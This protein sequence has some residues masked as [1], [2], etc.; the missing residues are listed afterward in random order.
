[1]RLSVPASPKV[2][3]K[4]LTNFLGVDYTSILPSTRRS[5]HL[6]N[7]TNN[8]GY[9]ETRPGYDTIGH[10]FGKRSRFIY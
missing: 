3:T 7:V 2:F 6:V 9:L 1:M 5:S 4:V 8:N 10:E